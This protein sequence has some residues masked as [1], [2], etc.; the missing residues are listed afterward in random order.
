MEE[1]E[2]MENENKNNKLK[3]VIANGLENV[4]NPYFT[5]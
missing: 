2:K 1:K 4:H 5:L 3:D